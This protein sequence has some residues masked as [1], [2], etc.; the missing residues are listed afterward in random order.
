MNHIPDWR[1]IYARF[2]GDETEEEDSSAS[3]ADNITKRKA[4]DT[5]KNALSFSPEKRKAKEVQK[6]KST[7]NPVQ[8][9][10]EKVCQLHL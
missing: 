1:V 2:I 4:L 3:D 8:V 5:D 7:P 10:P 6:T 9:Y